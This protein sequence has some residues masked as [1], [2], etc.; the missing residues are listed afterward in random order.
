MKP[1]KVGQGLQLLYRGYRI[2]VRSKPKVFQLLV[3][4]GDGPWLMYKKDHATEQGALDDVERQKKRILKHYKEWLH[5]HGKRN[6]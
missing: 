3:F 5:K 4:R 2:E 6:Y 1:E